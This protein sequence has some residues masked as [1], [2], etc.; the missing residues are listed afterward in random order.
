MDYKMANF[1]QNFTSAGLSTLSFSVPLAGIYP[2]SGKI[3]LPSIV[4]GGGASACVTTVSQTPLSGSPSVIYTGPAGAEGF[5]L[6]VN[7]AA[8]DTMTVVFSS[9]AAPDQ[10]L[11]VIKASISFG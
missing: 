7:C 3:L 9:A 8:Q 10:G 11:N 4:D 1:N 6:V 5:A 2:M